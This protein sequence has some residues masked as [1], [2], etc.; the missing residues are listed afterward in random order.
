MPPAA[1]NYT[2]SIRRKTCA[3]VNLDTYE[4]S[5]FFKTAKAFD[6]KGVPSDYYGEE[7]RDLL[8]L[9][10]QKHWKTF[11]SRAIDLK[12]N[13]VISGGTSSGK[14]TFLNACLHQIPI[15]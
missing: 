11:L 8:S 6:L 1:N 9:Y 5:G 4:Q 2:L 13:I 12:K 7:E 3:Q 14:T 15:E 10:Q